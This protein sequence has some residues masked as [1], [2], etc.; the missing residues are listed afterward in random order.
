MHRILPS[1]FVAFLLLIQAC[2]P[3]CEKP[4]YGEFPIS[5]A[6]VSKMAFTAPRARTFVSTQGETQ[7][8]TYFEPTNGLQEGTYDCE[9]DRRCGVCCATFDAGFFYS[10]LADA[11][12][13]I[14]FEFA[15]AKDFS[16]H[17]PLESNDSITEVLDI[18]YNTSEITYEIPDAPNSTLSG[19]IEL[20]GRTFQNV[21]RISTSVPPIFNDPDALVRFY[22][23]YEEGIVGFQYADSTIWRLE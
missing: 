9:L 5:N 15:L 12:N 8:L 23:S 20:D 21:Q 19:T 2:C 4:D 13:S 10:Q 17:S 14:R 16:R 11:D 7:T 18:A 1:F 6:G 3:P 22:F